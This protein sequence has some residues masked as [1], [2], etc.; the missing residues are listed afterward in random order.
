MMEDEVFGQVSKNLAERFRLL[1]TA[2]YCKPGELFDD[3][4]FHG[5]SEAAQQILDGT[6]VFLPNTDPATRLLFE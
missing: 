6:Y 5:D 3:I 4:G 2:P 1:F